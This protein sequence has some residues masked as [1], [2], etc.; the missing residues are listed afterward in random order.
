VYVKD[1]ETTSWEAGK[2]QQSTTYLIELSHFSG[3]RAYYNTSNP[4][5]TIE[6]HQRIP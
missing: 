2:G 3:L 1:A 5:G 6:L 4:S